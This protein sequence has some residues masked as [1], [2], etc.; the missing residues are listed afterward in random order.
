MFQVFVDPTIQRLIDA[1]PGF[2]PRAEGTYLFDLAISCPG[3][4]DHPLVEVGTYCGKSTLYLASA[5]KIRASTVISIDHHNG[6]EENY[7]PFPYFDQRLTHPTSHDLDTLKNFRETVRLSNLSDY[8]IA[9]VGDSN[10]YVK[11]FPKD[12]ASFVFID[13]GH[14]AVQTWT[15]FIDWSPKLI[16]GGVLAIHDVFEDPSQGGRPP[17]EIVNALRHSKTFK[18]LVQVGSLAAFKRET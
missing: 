7:P 15:D 14:S 12:T 16:H 18:E 4:S 8:I 5:A 6:S 2:M 10:Q 3:S 11:Y 1:T 17:F 9:V 13:G